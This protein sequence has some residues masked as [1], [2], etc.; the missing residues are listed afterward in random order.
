MIAVSQCLA[1]FPCRYDGGAKKDAKIEAM[2]R[3]GEAVCICPE[4][5]GGMS[6]PRDPC[7]IQGGDGGDV[8]AGRARVISCRGADCTDAYVRGAN[9]ALSICQRAGAKKAILKARS[10]S[11]GY[12]EIYDGTFSG[13]CKKGNGVTSA[14]LL[15][16]NIQIETR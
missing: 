16:H 1:G 9:E 4:C 13:T 10:P 3:A 2:V 12:G 7:E 5:M 8:L 15:A 14:L 11:C 6:T